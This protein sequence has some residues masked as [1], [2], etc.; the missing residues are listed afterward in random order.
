[1]LDLKVFVQC[2]A[3]VQLARRIR[4]D[5]VERGREVQGVLD[6]Y[7]RFVKPSFETSVLPTA[8]FADIVR[9]AALKPS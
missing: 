5:I 8:K 2:D 6:Q 1:M 9:R 4:R 3:D 7:L